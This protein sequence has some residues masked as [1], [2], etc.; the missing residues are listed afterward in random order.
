VLDSNVISLNERRKL[1][2]LKE[3]EKEFKGYLKSLKQ[4]QLQFEANY[5]IEKINEEN[6]SDEFLL[7]S[8]LL[9][10]ELAM[11]IN[12]ENMANTINKFALNL[13]SKVRSNQ[14]LN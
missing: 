8:A 10:D 1:K 2:E 3:T 6:L 13:R 12:V 7:K 14:L 5:I 4:D 9:M 11:R